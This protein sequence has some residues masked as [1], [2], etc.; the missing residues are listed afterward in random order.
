MT[1]KNTAPDLSYIQEDLRPLA[2]AIN[3]P[4]LDPRNARAHPE[5]NK[6]QIKLSLLK[7]GQCKPVVVNR[8]TGI[9]EAGNGMV[10]A[11]RELGWEFIAVSKADH[12]AADAL[13]YGIMDNKSGLSSTW[14]LEHLKDTLQELDT[15]AFEMKYTGFSTKEIEELMT[16]YHT[17][18]AGGPGGT[19]PGAL[20]ER[21]IAPP[22]SILDSR[23]GYWQERK[24]LWL[25]LGL[26]SELGRGDVLASMANAFKANKVAQSNQDITRAE[27]TDIPAWAVTSIFD[28]VLC[29]LVYSWFTPLGGSVL[30]PFA[31]GS[32][33][34][35]VAAYLGR[36]YTGIDLRAEQ[37]EANREQ[38]KL[39]A[40]RAMLAA[41]GISDPGALTPVESLGDVWVK[42]DDK[43]SVAGVV[44]GKART[45]WYLAQGA[46]GLVTAGSRVSPQ[47]NIVAHIAR[48]LSIPCRVHVPS[49]ELS[50]EVESAR[51][52]GAEVV[53]HKP[54]YN[55]VIIARA[56]E[57][58]EARGWT[59][60][61]FGMECAEAVKQ[62]RAQA[63]NIP[64]GVKRIV[65]AVGS[66]MSLAG[67][68]WG[69]KDAG[70]HIPVIGVKVGADP[71]K[72]LK[73]Y[74]PPD[75]Q[76]RVI[77][78]ESGTDYHAE[79]G[80]KVFRGLLLDPIYEAKCAPL[81]QAGDL[82]WVVGIRE[83]AITAADGS[84]DWIAG[85]SREGDKLLPK[86]EKYDL[87]F[88][89]PPYFDLELYDEDKRDLCN[90]ET[91]QAFINDLAG[92]IKLG[93]GRLKD[94]RF[95]VLVV[96]DIRD[97]AGYYRHFVAD[98]VLLAEAAGLRL[99]NDAVLVNVV[100]TASVRANR[101]FG[102]YR[103][104]V[105]THQNILVFYK[106]NL[107]KIKN[108]FPEVAVAD[109]PSEE[110]APGTEA[111]E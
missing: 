70:R 68:L 52:A 57:D 10:E 85:D 30:D 107:E 66:G 75:W 17:G 100:G 27:V 46:R 101:Y 41:G 38:Y 91:Y 106:G 40:P 102:S 24:R 110:T 83:T 51:A 14:Q 76:E 1:G 26:K 78:E 49:G 74:A 69:L 71:V 32:V 109:F 67:L 103:K 33:R 22:F 9:I 20:M 111:E 86:G 77:L 84:A 105:K 94:N 11:A 56:R 15:G 8:H 97:K 31:G 87:L 58:A 73:E 64:E 7:F 92:I 6:D 88:T 42:R 36:R 90:A 25:G 53:Q 98:T 39:M 48:Y 65:I 44:G 96:S 54:G 35:L 21:F 43:F 72:R 99:Y 18:G 28:P 104:L 93:A 16:Q 62:T 23:Q 3:S 50:P 45:C 12:N 4:I 80:E 95:A 19:G 13:A 2:V 37:V 55:S 79:A 108:E 29:E 59:N 34:G 5:E 63:A 60:I 89:C 61:P 47:V 82:L 81:L